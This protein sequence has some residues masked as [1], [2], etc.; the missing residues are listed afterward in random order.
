MF[1]TDPD[2]DGLRRLYAVP[3]SPADAT[4]PFVRA[5]FIM[6][7]DG[8]VTGSDGVS[9]SINN[10]AD[11]QVFDLL[12]SLADTVLV[13]AGTVR[14]EGY[15]RVEAPRS[16]RAPAIVVVSD[17]GVMPKSIVDSPTHDDGV[18]RGPAFLATTESA[19]QSQHGVARIVCGE[20]SVDE[21]ALLKELHARGAR[22]VL[23]EG[24]PHLLTSLL[25]RGLVDELAITTSPMLVGAVSRLRLMTAPL[26]IDLD[27]RGGAV[28]D[29]TVFSLWRVRGRR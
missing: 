8:H 21:K 7:A 6:T 9:G 17:S 13:G 27:W 22:S 20:T 15:E 1:L 2:L 5:N 14:A 4:R 26:Q 23:C 11:K 29:G 10:P 25:E 12:R 16:A 19:P 3:T 18:P 24:G 28:L